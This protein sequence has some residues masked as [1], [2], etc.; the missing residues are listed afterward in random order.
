MG[1]L[2]APEIPAHHAVV[3]LR[4]WLQHTEDN[5]GDGEQDR[6]QDG[7]ERQPAGNPR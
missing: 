7:A 5:P 1:L 3:C 4:G 6:P 2:M